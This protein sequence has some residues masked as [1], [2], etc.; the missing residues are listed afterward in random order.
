MIKTIKN[1]KSKNMREINLEKNQEKKLS[2]TKSNNN[3]ASWLIPGLW[4]LFCATWVILSITNGKIFL[5]KILIAS[6]II[7]AVLFSHGFE[8]NHDPKGKVRNK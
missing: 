5:D 4:M 3:I 2:A 8:V 6:F 7:S 1:Q